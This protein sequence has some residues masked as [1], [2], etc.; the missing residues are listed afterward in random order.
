MIAFLS[1]LVIKGPSFALRHFF[2]CGAILFRMH[3]TVELKR[4]KSSI[5]RGFELSSSATSSL[6]EKLSN[7]L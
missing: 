5:F 4:V 2:F 6:K 1:S 3:S 7:P